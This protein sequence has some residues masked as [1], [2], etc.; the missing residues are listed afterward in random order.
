MN[1]KIGVYCGRPAQREKTA[2]SVAWRGLVPVNLSK[3]LGHG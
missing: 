1:A 2:I 3:W